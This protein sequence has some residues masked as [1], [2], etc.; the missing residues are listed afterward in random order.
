MLGVVYGT[1]DARQGVGPNRLELLSGVK[2]TKDEKSFW[3]EKFSKNNYVFGKIP[4]KF[5]AQNYQYIPPQSTVLDIGMGEGRNAVFLA[6]KGY[7]V[8]GIDISSVAIKKARALASEFGVRINSIATSVEKFVPEKSFDAI[9]CFYYVDR[10]VVTKMLSWLKPGGIII[11]ESHTEKQKGVKGY[12]N[13]N[14]EYLLKPGELLTLF[15]GAQILKFEEPL[16]YQEFTS[17]IIVKK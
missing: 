8:T 9:I 2:R 7:V 14:I 5:L 11:F 4:A 13:Y 3:D 15:K 16:H 12:E 6:Q 10:K 17:S 1:T